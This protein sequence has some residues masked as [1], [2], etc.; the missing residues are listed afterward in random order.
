MCLPRLRLRLLLILANDAAPRLTLTRPGAHSCDD[1]GRIE[2]YLRPHMLL[3][4]L[5]VAPCIARPFALRRLLSQETCRPRAKRFFAAVTAPPRWE[6]ID[7]ACRSNGSITVDIVHSSSASSPTIIYVPSGPV[8]L[9]QNHEEEQLVTA[10]AASSGATIARVNY[11][12]STQ[13]PFPTP[14]HDVLA[15]YDW[16]LEN[17]PR[18]HLVETLGVCGELVGGSLATML[19]LTECRKGGPRIG[20]AAVNNPIADWV[21]PDDLPAVAPEALPEPDA[22]EETSFPADRDFMT[23]WEK[24]DEVEGVDAPKKLVKRAPKKKP[25]S[26]WESNRENLLLS[27]THLLETRDVLF[28]RPEHCFDRFAS[29]TLFFRSPHAKLIY[30]WHDDIFASSSPT[31]VP[32]PL[33]PDTQMSLDHFES[34][35][36]QEAAPPEAPTM[37]RCRAYARVHPPANAPLDLPQFNITAGAHSPLLDQNTELAKLIKRG[38]VRHMLKSRTGRTQWHDEEEK[39]KYEEVAAEVVRLNAV[40]G[41]GLWSRFDANPNWRAN[42]EN[43]GRWM[44]Q[45]LDP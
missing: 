2:G 25:I 26:S 31:N 12:A 4:H 16:V 20:A 33:D 32:E 30:P 24:Q 23:W 40:E 13:H 37:V 5:P 42:V 7:V 29:P 43:V 34:L 45:A 22:P 15:G 35:E 10:L 17:L 1:R 14:I 8:F 44:R 11:R 41:T 36:S 9:D 38:I 3:G 6:R 18:R 28:R 27:T 19:A 21:F 39:A